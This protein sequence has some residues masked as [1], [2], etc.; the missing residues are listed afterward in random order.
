[1][2]TP[3]PTRPEAGQ[4]RGDLFRLLFEE[5]P[6]G[7]GLEVR[8]LPSHRWVHGIGELKRSASYA[9]REPRNAGVTLVSFRRDDARQW[10]CEDNALA[11]RFLWADIDGGV[12][13]MGGALA[14]LKGAVDGG[15]VPA[16]HV[17]VATGG[18]YHALWVLDRLI[19]LRTEEVRLRHKQTLKRIAL[20]IG[21]VQ[22]RND[23]GLVLPADASEAFADPGAAKL[24]FALRLPGTLNVKRDFLVKIV[25]LRLDEPREAPVVWRA[26]LPALPAPPERRKPREE[27]GPRDLTVPPC[28]MA[29][30]NGICP[31]HTRHQRALSIAGAL[32]AIGFGEAAIE[33]YLERFAERSGWEPEKGEVHKIALWA[34]KRTEGDGTQA[35]GAHY[36]R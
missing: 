11:T 8:T 32:A 28:V 14:R 13:G 2:T 19:D 1:M 18:G 12:D 36:G 17:L 29:Q 10:A 5:L 20:A 9:L 33:G 4:G 16:P 27:D 7:G 25:R 21:G 3:A 22:A 31:P 23:Q 15:R 6:E 30:I 24:T 34:G 35:G 26:R